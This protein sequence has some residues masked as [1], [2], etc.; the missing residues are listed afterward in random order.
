MIFFDGNRAKTV[1]TSHE[2]KQSLI[3]LLKDLDPDE[4]EALQVMLEQ[5]EEGE[6]ELV[7]LMAEAQWE[8]EPVSMEQF[9]DDPYYMGISAETLYPKIRE[10]LI[11]LFED[12]GYSEAILSGAIG[13]GKTMMASMI[14]VRLLYE[15]SCLREPQRSYGLSPGSE[16][17]MVL[18]S[19]N[20]ILARRVLMSA[21]K[22]KLE[23]SPYFQ[24]EFPYKAGSEEIKFPK[25]IVVQIGSV[26]SERVLGLNVISAFQD[27]AN[28]SAAKSAVIKR[29]AGER[30]DIHHFDAAEKLYTSINM[31]IKSRFLRGGRVPGMNVLLS[32]RTTKNCFTDRR[33]KASRLDPTVIC[34][35]YATWDVK[36]ARG[37]SK[38]WFRVLVGGVTVRSR[39]MKKDEEL[40]EKF[41]Q[42]TDST[43]VEVPEDYR[44]DFESDLNKAIRDVA[45]LSTDAINAFLS[46]HEKIFEAAERGEKMG[47][48]HPFTVTEYTY[49]QNGD[50]RWDLLVESFKRKL[51]GGHIEQAWKPKV[52]PSAHRHVH[53][54]TSLSGDATG[55]AMGRIDR[56]IDVV[57]RGPDGK[58]Y[59]ELAPVIVIEF[60]LRILP[61]PGEQIFLPDVRRLVYQL[62]ERG[63]PI[64]SFSCDSYQSA[65]MLQQ[66]KTRGVHAEL[67]SVDTKTDPYDKLKS[68]M[69]EDRLI[70]YVYQPFI[71]EAVALEYDYE[72][73]KVDHPL[74]F[75]KDVAD[76]VAGVVEGLH[77]FALR[78]P[79]PMVMNDDENRDED[80][81]HKWVLGDKKIP[82]KPTTRRGRVA[83]KANVVLP[84]VLKD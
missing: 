25:G 64:N 36:P 71:D 82:V 44:N 78:A 63:Y 20:L 56:W 47:M 43:V 3:S 61:P 66:V 76:A 14:A 58:E 79:M 31:R 27:E 29:G 11:M 45:G 39:I 77:R 84:P 24:E 51:K 2:T 55:V 18:L 57:R 75:S 37:F 12:G 33:V 54:D 5:A 49:G 10:D 21:V 62:M 60:M 7:D 4:R 9:L 81:D 19:K 30:A 59:A 41:L 68:A 17:H 73:G 34:F 6:G 15:L 67:I 53:I 38:K 72:K 16:L 65:E 1:R 80:G 70:M 23:V 69:Y 13:W 8:R 22:E 40:P 74:A 32:S 52:K 42:D 83:G 28:F 26:N 50:F 48:E 35:D 46:R